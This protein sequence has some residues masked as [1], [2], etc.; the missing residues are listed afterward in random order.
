RLRRRT[1][2]FGAWSAQYGLDSGNELTHAEWFGE[3]VIGPHRQSHQ[4]IHLLGTRGGDQHVAI[5]ERA[6]LPHHLQTVETRKAEIE[7]DHVRR[8]GACSFHG[9][10]TVARARGR[11]AGLGQVRLSQVTP[12]RFVFVD[13]NVCGCSFRYTPQGFQ[14]GLRS[15]TPRVSRRI[16]TRSCG[17][18]DEIFARLEESG[19][20]CVAYEL[21]P[22]KE[23]LDDAYRCDVVAAV[24]DGRRPRRSP[25]GLGV[26]AGTHCAARA[27]PTCS[28]RERGDRRTLPTPRSR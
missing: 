9:L 25:L 13:E 22:L 26:A 20:D 23:N 11:V 6:D 24:G 3:I 4:A 2:G 19:G 21:D 28:G 1:S 14:S 18:L 27:S 16:C 17:T 7:D 12:R 8:H 5:G 15:W 10:R